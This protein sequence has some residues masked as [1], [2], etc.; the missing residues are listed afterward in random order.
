M[1]TYPKTKEDYIEVWLTAHNNPVALHTLYR[2][3]KQWWSKLQFQDPTHIMLQEDWESEGKLKFLATWHTWNPNG[4]ANFPTYIF[5]IVLNHFNNIL[6]RLTVTSTANPSNC[7]TVSP[8]IARKTS[9]SRTG[10]DHLYTLL[11]QDTET[12]Q[13]ILLEQLQKEM[14]HHKPEII[15]VLNYIINQNIAIPSARKLAKELPFRATVITKAVNQIR[16]LIHEVANTYEVTNG[17]GN[18]SRIPNL[19]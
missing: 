7:I 6:K 19:L 9:L 16:Q 12:E 1:S 5:R 3:S 13:Q 15:E 11:L 18:P 4:T 10:Y 17:Y 14:L 2:Y 8:V